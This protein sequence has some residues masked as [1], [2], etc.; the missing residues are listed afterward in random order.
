MLRFG[1]KL[2]I[3]VV[4]LIILQRLGLIDLQVLLGAVHQPGRLAVAFLF[5]LATVPLAAL[6]WS[7]L[8]HALKFRATFGWSLQ[9]TFV[10]LFFHT[11]LPGA[12]GGDLVRLAIAY[13]AAGSGINRLAFSI[14]VDRISGLVALLV[15]GLA[16]LPVIPMV[17]AGRFGWIVAAVLAGGLAAVSIALLAGDKL[18]RLLSQL[19]KPVGPKLALVFDELLG[20]LKA[21]ASKPAAVGYSVVLSLVQYVFVLGALMVLGDAMGF[22]GLSAAGYVIAGTWS[23]VANALPITPGGLGIGEATFGKIAME[24]ATPPA[25]LGFAS[26]FLAMRVLSI[27]ISV[28]GVLPFSLRRQEILKDLA[29]IRTAPAEQEAKAK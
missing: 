9:V 16:V 7:I 5:L 13:R 15:L 21:Y 22:E 2:A 17:Y 4:G 8:L 18:V 27:A 19:P 24:L 6:R 23:L 3:G 11:F 26:I 1:I 28:V 29:T 20:A 25:S 12:Y 14:L 10:S